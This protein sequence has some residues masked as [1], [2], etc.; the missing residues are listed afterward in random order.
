MTRKI[1][2]KKGEERVRMG[3]VQLTSFIS[4]SS[5]AASLP[6]HFRMWRTVKSNR[7]HSAI[8]LASEP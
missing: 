2:K 1:G 6:R 7:F 8:R 3:A 5:A 4:V